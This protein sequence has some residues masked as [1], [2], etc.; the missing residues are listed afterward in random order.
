MRPSRRSPSYIIRNQYSYCFRMI[1]PKD[2]QPF[3]RIKELR[4]SLNTGY[5]GIAKSKARLI[6]GL[7]Q[8]TFREMREI[9]KMGDLTDEKIQ[10]MVNRF[11]RGFLD[12]FE[13]LRVEMGGDSQKMDNVDH[14]VKIFHR[15]CRR[16]QDQLQECNYRGMKGFVDPMLKNEGIEVKEGTPLFNKISREY[17]K[18]M[19]KFGQIDENQHKGNY[20]DDVQ[21]I[22]QFSFTD[23]V[24]R[25]ETCVLL[26]F[27]FWMIKPTR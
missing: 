19:I 4:Y 1:I 7:T 26:S 16:S 2:L 23:I 24:F 3:F 5:L 21:T 25:I 12:L 17:L 15:V 14:L 22:F 8:Q 18:A 11:F 27:F 10:E 9:V 13:D 20:S 6:A